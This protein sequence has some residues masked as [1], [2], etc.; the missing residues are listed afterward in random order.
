MQLENNG[1]IFLIE[2]ECEPEVCSTFQFDECEL[3][4]DEGIAEFY[5]EE[6]IECITNFIDFEAT[7]NTEVS[8]YNTLSDAQ[9]NTNQV[10]TEPFLNTINPQYLTVRIENNATQELVYTSIELTATDC[11]D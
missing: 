9:N 2:K 7:E 11:E 1:I 10:A 3:N 6:Y 5:L 8:F 4:Q